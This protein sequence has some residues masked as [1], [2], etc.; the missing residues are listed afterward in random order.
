MDYGHI[1]LANN[2]KEWDAQIIKF[3]THSNFSHSVLIIPPILSREMCV[4]AASIGVSAL[5]F[6]TGYR[7]NPEQGFEI[8]R[9]KADEETKSRAIL[10]CLDML[11][12]P[13]GYL[14]MPWFIW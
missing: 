12:K 10:A 8:W 7:S 3:I 11:E 1:V 5:P 6:D 9:L 14:E 2:K 4:E 13:Y